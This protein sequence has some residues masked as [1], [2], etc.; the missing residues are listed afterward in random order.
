MLRYQKIIVS[1]LAAA[2]MALVPAVSAHADA[3][4]G[5]TTCPSPRYLTVTGYSD[6]YISVIAG[7]RSGTKTGSGLQT[8]TVRS[9]QSGTVRWNVSNNVRDGDTLRHTVNCSSV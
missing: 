1:G 6:N 7:S 8:L 9:Y 5:T 3:I 2:L 4:T